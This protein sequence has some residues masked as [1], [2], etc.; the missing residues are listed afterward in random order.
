MDGPLDRPADPRPADLRPVDPHPG[1]LQPTE[2]ERELAA[3]AA[4]QA[5]LADVDRALE[6]IDDGSYGMCE[7]CGQPIPDEVLDRA[8]VARL[9]EAHP[10]PDA[11][12]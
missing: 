3:L 1:D 9:C 2:R 7:A 11:R 4:V 6:R 10:Q 8:P 5:A 12:R